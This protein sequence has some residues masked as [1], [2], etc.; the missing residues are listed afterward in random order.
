V[1]GKRVSKSAEP[2]MGIGG[3]RAALLHA[4]LRTWAP[5]SLCIFL[6]E[7]KAVLK[8]CNTIEALM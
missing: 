7:G 3:R 4:S 8:S 2:F 6:S 5:S 1:H